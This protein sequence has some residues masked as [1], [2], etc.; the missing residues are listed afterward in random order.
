M[1]MEELQRLYLD[2]AIELSNVRKNSK[3]FFRSISSG[4]E[5][6]MWK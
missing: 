2:K 5:D 4:F 1:K 3:L 6:T